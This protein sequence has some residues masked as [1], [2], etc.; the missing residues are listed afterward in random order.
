MLQTYTIS[1]TFVIIK[2]AEMNE[3]LKM[4]ME[5][6]GLTAV[7]FA[8]IMEVQP[9]GISHLLS[10]RNMP[11]FDFI[12]KLLL[13]FPQV[14][15][16]WIINSKGEMYK[17]NETADSQPDSVNTNVTSD[18]VAKSTVV[19]DSLITPVMS[20]SPEL[21]FDNKD[22]QQHHNSSHNTDI[23]SLESLESRKE[24][25]FTNVNSVRECDINDQTAPSIE[26]KHSEH[27]TEDK[28][29]NTVGISKSI[30]RVIVIYSDGTFDDYIK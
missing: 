27:P 11:N 6:E 4:L 2:V 29:S 3:R 14:N 22:L 28:L 30:S 15:P 25:L 16:D 24:S 21:N 19:N 1:R 20:I 8:E 26:S 10:G 7:K 5:S 17:R 23:E 18:L 13:R 12:S 9:S